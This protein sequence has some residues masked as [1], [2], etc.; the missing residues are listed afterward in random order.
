MVYCSQ[1]GKKNDDDADFCKK[2]GAI[3]KKEK[4]GFEENIDHFA[5]E[6]GQIGEK[7]EKAF[8]KK[9]AKI[10]KWY[11]ST[12]GPIGPIIS[13]LIGLIVLIF[14]IKLLEFLA[15]G[16]GWM[17]DVSE[18]FGKY[19]LLFFVFML[20]SS[21]AS[22]SSRRY[23]AFRSASPIVAAV[24]FAIWFWVAIEILKILSTDLDIEIL[25]SI[26]DIFQILLIP[27][28]IL[29]LL[30]GYTGMILSSKKQEIIKPAKKTVEKTTRSS[31]ESKTDDVSYKRLYRSGKDKWIAGVCGG[32]AEYFQ[33]DPVIV[34]I[35]FVFAVVATAVFP[36]FLAYIIFWIVVPRNPNHKW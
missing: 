11:D 4:T 31:K 30:V 35:L 7:I 9:E 14:I 36:M 32:L 10:D 17:M 27:I 33:I 6:M 2:C 8:E 3:I 25:G 34:R 18:F 15:D 29:V 22:Y 5:E 13:S 16:R 12:F 24:G 20:F 21:Y 1:C 28:A 26:A 19:L 23:K